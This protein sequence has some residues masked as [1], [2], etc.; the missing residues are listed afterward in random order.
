V[1]HVGL[2]FR[3]LRPLL[4]E[5]QRRLF[6]AVE[7]QLLGPGSISRVAA[8]TGLSR[9]TIHRGVEELARI[10]THPEV[11]A[12]CR[13]RGGGR[14]PVTEELPDLLPTLESL[15]EPTGVSGPDAAPIRWTFK[16]MRELAAELTACGFWVSH[17]TVAQTLNSHGFRVRSPISGDRNGARKA[18]VED[19]AAFA[20]IH[21]AAAEGVPV[22]YMAAEP[23]GNGELWAA[24][25]TRRCADDLPSAAAQLLSR[26]LVGLSGLE[27]PSAGRVALCLQIV[28]TEPAMKVIWL[29]S[30][31]KIGRSLKL[32]FEVHALPDATY[33]WQPFNDELLCT[34]ALRSGGRARANWRFHLGCLTPPSWV[35]A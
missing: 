9:T 8:A 17:G 12:S 1:D 6:L 21:Q 18:T 32:R 13:R 28:G 34:Y 33:R 24:D 31:M 11:V 16:S 23:D 26:F 22:V 3:L 19:E 15:F 7:T 14:K 10:E 29:N 27:R 2:R 25:P 4:T 20:K 30:I 5:R 35:A